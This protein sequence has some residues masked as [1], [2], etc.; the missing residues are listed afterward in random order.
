MKKLIA[1]VGMSG[2]GKSIVTD[3][4]EQQG[5]T[6][7]YFGGITYKLM[8]EAGIIRTEDGKSE[9]EFREN[10]RNAPPGGGAGGQ[11]DAFRAAMNSGA[12]PQQPPRIF[13]PLSRHW[14]TM[15]A[16]SSGVWG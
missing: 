4:L 11:M 8:D 7:L 1:V 15:A 12:V 2:T 5:W 10:L 9:K 3:Y 6:K 14:R 16:N 13:A